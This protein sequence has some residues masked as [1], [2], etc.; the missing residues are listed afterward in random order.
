L[1]QTGFTLI[2]LLVVIAVIGILAGIL[3][4][5]LARARESARR[6]ACQNNMRQFGIIF[7]MYA[8]ENEGD[9]PPAA[10]YGSVRSDGLSSALFEAPQGSSIVPEYLTDTGIARCPS[11]AGGDPGWSSVG[12]RV[13][14]GAIDFQAWQV[15]ALAANDLVSFDYYLSAELARSYMYKGYLAR[16]RFEYYGIWGA[17]TTNP[18]EGDA[19][20]LGLDTVRIKDYTE[21]LP[22]E[23]GLW[24]AWVPAP[25]LAKGAYGSDSI[26][27][28]R[29]GAERFYITNINAPSSASASE[30]TL[31]VMWDTY[32]SGEFAD[33]ESG[34][35]AFNH[36]AGGSNVLYMDGHVE[37]IRYPVAFP[38]VSD[39][40]VV[41]E[42]SH[43]GLG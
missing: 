22:M 24:P 12:P 14:K 18:V 39:E 21:D 9:F 38:I 3:L 7:S 10:P 29:Q 19:A 4:P 1:G 20:I 8:G 41:K 34:G 32:G 2:E 42:N 28:I 31:A 30:S 5:A 6:A 23:L 43:H 16:D 27:R 37:F 36:I 40:R 17:K 13:P 15:N 26:V 33:N 25:P 11:D 35:I